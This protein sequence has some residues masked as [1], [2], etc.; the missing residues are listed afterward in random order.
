MNVVNIVY[1]SYIILIYNKMYYSIVLMYIVVYVCVC[2]QR[3]VHYHG[4]DLYY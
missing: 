1:L 3:V 2:Q 4:N